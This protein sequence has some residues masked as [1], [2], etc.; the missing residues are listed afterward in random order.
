MLRNLS[1]KGLVIIVSIAVILLGIDSLKLSKYK[2]PELQ[3]AATAKPYSPF[4]IRDI[5]EM[6]EKESLA[7]EHRR[8][9]EFISYKDQRAREAEKILKVIQQKLNLRPFERDFWTELIKM[10]QIANESP[11]TRIWSAGNAI[12]IGGWESKFRSNIGLICLEVPPI[13]IE[14]DPE[15]CFRELIY[16]SLSSSQRSLFLQG[17][18]V[19]QIGLRLDELK[20]QYCFDCE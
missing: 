13:L 19:K 3:L 16:L 17:F 7:R 5:K 4:F 11:R 10:Q 6:A 14:I 18:D 2:D 1:I 9:L 20:G 15:F 12:L 8:R